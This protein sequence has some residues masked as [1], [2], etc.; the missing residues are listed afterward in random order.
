MDTHTTIF[1]VRA[2]T[3]HA[4]LRVVSH[5]DLEDGLLSL[6]DNISSIPERSQNTYYEP[7][8]KRRLPTRFTKTITVN[9]PM[10]V[11]KSNEMRNVTIHQYVEE[12][13]KLWASMF[14][15]I[16]SF[17]NAPKAFH[18]GVGVNYG[19]LK[20]IRMIRKVDTSGQTAL[21]H[22][23]HLSGRYQFFHKYSHAHDCPDILQISYI[24]CVWSL[25]TS[26]TP[27]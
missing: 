26:R 1:Q 17:E 9:I 13:F 14:A 5:L 10:S 22:M 7:H 8:T 25:Q 21:A 27:S 23:V 18:G 19:D 15:K 16:S 24:S 11:D 6:E 12:E 20:Q 2:D 3:T 4:V